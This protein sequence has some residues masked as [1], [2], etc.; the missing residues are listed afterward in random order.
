MG[1]KKSQTRQTRRDRRKAKASGWARL[2]KKANVVGHGT[3]ATQKKV[4]GGRKSNRP[5]Y[6][7]K[8]RRTDMPLA[9]L[10]DFLYR[11]S[12]PLRDF[13]ESTG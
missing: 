6:T 11:S 2:P 8:P 12:A 5:K 4:D 13:D 10:G 1:S 3:Q 7:G 9:T